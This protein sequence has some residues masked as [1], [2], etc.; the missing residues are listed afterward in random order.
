MPY[1]GIVRS[2]AAL[3]TFADQVISDVV[4]PEIELPLRET[5]FPAGFPVLVETNSRDVIEAAKE[6]WGN[7][8]RLFD[9]TPVRLSLG[10]TKSNAGLD[11]TPSRYFWREHLMSLY[12]GRENFLLCDFEQGFAA[13]SVTEAVAMDHPLLR[14]RFLTPGGLLLV[15]QKALAP[16]H[17]AL[18]ARKGCGVVLTGESFAGKS[19]LAYACARAGWT[20]LSDDG[21]L[22]VRDRSDRY[23]V[24]DPYTLRLRD[25]ARRFFP[26]LSDHLA[27]VRPNGKIAIEIRTQE[28]PIT[29]EHGV[30]VDHVVRLAR[31]E[32]GS[33]RLEA[34][35]KRQAWEGCQEHTRFGAASVR[36]SQR[37]CLERLL[38]AGTWELQYSRLED[39]ISRL[40]QLVDTGA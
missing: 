27:V 28:L 1:S 19:T 23:A 34:W 17:G 26:E 40:E 8:P 37:A 5:L 29:I 39:A 11:L 25:D 22:L 2:A 4:L 30:C 32:S 21:T 10:V 35:P 3:K 24:G 20:Y 16:L 15:E 7:F 6:G 12:A 31:R 9:H 33:A 14:Y 18:I 38:D 36:A 13:G